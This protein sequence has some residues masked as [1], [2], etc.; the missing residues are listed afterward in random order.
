MRMESEYYADAYYDDASVINVARS[1]MAEMSVVNDATDGD[2][3]SAVNDVTGGDVLLVDVEMGESR[4]RDDDVDTV[5]IDDSWG[6]YRHYR[7]IRRRVRKL[8]RQN[9]TLR[10][11]LDG[12]KIL[13]E[14]YE[15]A[16]E[17]NARLRL[18]N[19]VLR[20]ECMELGSR[21]KINK[22]FSIR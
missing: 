13:K 4:G 15:A 14:K 6:M 17:D 7:A 5:D 12:S 1:Q 3:L 20:A 2:V 9:E 8:K 10:R 22:R 21:L 19:E 16:Q 18:E 11:Q